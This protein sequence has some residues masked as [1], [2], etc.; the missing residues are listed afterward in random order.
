MAEVPAPPHF[1]N[2]THGPDIA[3]DDDPGYDSY[4]LTGD[5]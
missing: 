3:V 2:D 4:S 5:Q 1:D